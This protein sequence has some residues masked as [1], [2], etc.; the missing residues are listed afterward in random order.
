MA[1]TYSAEDYVY[2]HSKTVASV[3]DN[4]HLMTIKYNG[5]RFYVWGSTYNG[6]YWQ[7]RLEGSRTGYRTRAQAQAVYD[8][9]VAQI[10]WMRHDDETG[11]SA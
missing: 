2:L 6:R 3:Q 5:Y 11:M 4:S 7:P 9:Q 10:N 1:R 8:L